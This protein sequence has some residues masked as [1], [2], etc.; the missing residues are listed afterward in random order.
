MVSPTCRPATIMIR[1]ISLELNRS[2][3]NLDHITIFSLNRP[4]PRERDG[5]DELNTAAQT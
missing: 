4:G 5:C 1:P 3:C 2:S